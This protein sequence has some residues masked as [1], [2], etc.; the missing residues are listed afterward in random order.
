MN[1]LKA[2]YPHI[3][4]IVLGLVLVATFFSPI[5][6]SNKIINQNDVYQGVASASEII[7]YREATGK[8]ALWTN[9]MF[10]GMPAYLI[11]ISYSGEL[12]KY[13]QKLISVGLPSS[14]Q[15]IFLSFVSFYILLLVF[16]VRPVLAFAGAVAF[17]F[18][19][20]SLISVEAGHI[21]KVRAIAYMPLVIAGVHM[22]FTSSKRWLAVGLLSAAVALEI[23]ANHLQITYY[24]FLM[25]LAYGV[26]Q[27]ID[28]IRTKEWKQFSVKLAML[29]LA[30]VL[31]VGANAARLWTAAEYGQYSTRG[32]SDL[33]PQ[34]SVAGKS[35]LD[36]DYVFNWSYGIQESLTLLIPNFSGGA[37]T[38]SLDKDSKFG[39]ALSR[40]GVGGAQLRDQLKGVP[41][42]WGQQP[43][44]AG[45]SYAGAIVVLLAILGIY[46]VDRKM[47]FW[48]LSMAVLGLFLAWG[49]NFSAFNDLMY[50]YFPGYNKFRSVSMA[51]IIFLTAVPLL[52]FLGLENFLNSDDKL[53]WKKLLISGAIP[54]GLALIF[55]LFGGLFSFKGAVDVRFTQLPEWYVDAIRDQRKSLLTGDAWRTF[56]FVGLAVAAIYF[57]IKD[58]LKVQVAG[59]L[60][61][62]LVTADFWFVGKRFLTEDIY[63]RGNRRPKAEATAA[64][65]FIKQ[66]EGEN[67]YRVLNLQN[68][69]NE[70]TT[71][72]FH[73]SLGGYHGAKMKRYNELIEY[74]LSP[75]ISGLVEKL[76]S[77]ST[78]FQEFGVVN[79]LNTNY[80]KFGPNRENIIENSAAYGNAWF[81]NQLQKVNSADEEIEATCGISDKSLAIVNTQ[82]FPRLEDSY[83]HGGTIDLV[84]Y[85]PNYL[86]YNVN[87]AARGFAVFSEIYYPKGWKA[88]IDGQ[89]A[90]IIQANY[91]LRGLEIPSGA[92]VIEFSF[93]PQS[94][95]LGN[96]LT[97]VFSVLT[98]SLLGFALVVEIRKSL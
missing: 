18:N 64:D 20:F 25:L 97:L 67:H 42:Y 17:S 60:L 34:K 63:Q 9:R 36:R 51:M 12:I 65:Q 29:A 22:V 56:I 26:F 27:F 23:Y 89:D 52:A 94:Y 8:E 1:K 58:K 59:I 92:K 77:G 3:L 93:E 48:L 69:F 19:T 81:V 50:D 80:L 57:A 15:V 88:K 10:S 96:R 28:V 24:L 40:R 39:A 85:Q 55:A 41:T 54:A 71:S 68:P 98:L 73:S 37:S 74:C 16:K 45:P 11:N 31:G 62:F 90:N 46:F 84:E 91:V 79:M 43:I 21:W 14:A 32:K 6:F 76:R 5:I 4:A 78:D 13:V 7:E 33:S 49:K 70:A 47:R 66:S 44:V 72:A 61:A 2:L 38:M 82:K 75:S 86:K 30:A 87:N 83:Q 35:G 95:Y 53:K